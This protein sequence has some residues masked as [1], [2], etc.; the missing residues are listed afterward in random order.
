MNWDIGHTLIA[1]YLVNNEP[2]V[3]PAEFHGSPVDI[4]ILENFEPIYDIEDTQS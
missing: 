2:V 1:P 4:D 3:V